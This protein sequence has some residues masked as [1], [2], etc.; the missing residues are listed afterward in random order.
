MHEHKTEVVCVVVV[1]TDVLTGCATAKE[2]PLPNGQRGYVIG[3][4]DDMAECYKKAAETCGG[5]YA[6]VNQSGETVGVMSGAGGVVSGIAVPQYTM[7]IQCEGSSASP[8][9]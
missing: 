1:A 9:K 7:T 5:K 4:C 8:E 3:D 6:V 2:V